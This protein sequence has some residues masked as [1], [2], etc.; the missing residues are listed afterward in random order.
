MY[1][2]TQIINLQ[3]SISSSPYLLGQRLEPEAHP[4]L[5]EIRLRRKIIK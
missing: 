3:Y 5:E 1:F 4:P 2:F